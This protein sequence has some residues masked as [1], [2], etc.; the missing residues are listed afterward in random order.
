MSKE[1][2]S[3]L[4]E[5][6]GQDIIPS[7][8]PAGKQIVIGSVESVDVLEAKNRTQKLFF[9]LHIIEN[10]KHSKN[11]TVKNRTKHAFR[12]TDDK[13]ENDRT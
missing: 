2:Y 1:R 13:A 4:Q 12:R 11:R 9:L 8:E 3:R 5:I 7:Y 6:T 10:I